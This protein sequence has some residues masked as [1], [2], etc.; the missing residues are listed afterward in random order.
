MKPETYKCQL[1]PFP[2]H[3]NWLPLKI[4]QVNVKEGGAAILEHKT[5]IMWNYKTEKGPTPHGLLSYF[6]W[7]ILREHKLQAWKKLIRKE[8]I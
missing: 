6:I 2:V 1:R 5:E 7:Q 8:I 4:I 3:S